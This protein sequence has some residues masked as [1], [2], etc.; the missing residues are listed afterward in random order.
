MIVGSNRTNYKSE[1]SRKIKNWKNEIMK[2]SSIKFRSF[3]FLKYFIF[4]SWKKKEESIEKKK[5]KNSIWV[6]AG[7]FDR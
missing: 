5:A 1:G 3:I 4:I 6:A 7:L 2:C